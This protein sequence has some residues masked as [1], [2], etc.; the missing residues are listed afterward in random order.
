MSRR[1]IVMAG[2]IVLITGHDAQGTPS[3]R[4]IHPETCLSCH[5][6][7]TAVDIDHDVDVPPGPEVRLTVRTC[8]VKPGPAMGVGIMTRMAP[9]A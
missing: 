7:V 6:S 8:R 1:T 2:G 4:C 9:R 5:R 3:R